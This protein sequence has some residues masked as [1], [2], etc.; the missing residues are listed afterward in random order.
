MIASFIAAYGYV[1]LFIGTILEGETV[2]VAAGFA[3]HRGLLSWPFVVLVAM[4]GATLGD[5]S[6][7]LVGRW[8]GAALIGRFP[9]LARRKPR[10]DAL[11]ERYDY[12]FILTLRFLYGLR[13]AGPLVIGSTRVPIIRFAA[14]NMAGAAIWAAIFC[15]IGDVFGLVINAWLGDIKQ[16]EEVS[17]V[18]I[19]ALGVAFA[20]WR[21][22]R[23][24][25]D[26]T[27]R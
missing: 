12:L 24:R 25:R 23:S 14:F 8:K 21:R 20:L 6:W 7:F 15:A 19:L 13:V 4:A 3:A 9:A 22:Y 11:L 10:I 1:A 18:A 27:M 2:L 16:I 26:R 17:F 5:Q